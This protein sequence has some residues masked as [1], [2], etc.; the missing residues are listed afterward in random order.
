MCRYDNVGQQGNEEVNERMANTVIPENLSTGKPEHTTIERNSKQFYVI[1]LITTDSSCKPEL[2]STC[3]CSE[4]A[5]QI[6]QIERNIKLLK[7][8]RDINMLC[9]NFNT[10]QME[11]N[12]LKQDL[13]QAV[14]VT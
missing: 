8:Q 13:E 14:S 4:L 11:K 12:R 5:E 9:C 6:K 7:S 3:H 2:D 1:G 10:C